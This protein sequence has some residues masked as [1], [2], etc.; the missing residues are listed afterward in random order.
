[1]AFPSHGITHRPTVTGTRGMIA[2]AH[3]IASLAGARILL[4][5]GN[6]FDAAVA[7]ASTLNVVEPY[8]SG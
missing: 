5:G 3:P 4:Q 1:M 6:A 7:V 2:S 8:M